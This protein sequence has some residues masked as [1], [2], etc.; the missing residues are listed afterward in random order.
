M[1]CQDCNGCNGS[2]GCCDDVCTNGNNYLWYISATDPTEVNYTSGPIAV[3]NRETVKFISSVPGAIR[4]EKGSVN[5]YIDFPLGLQGCQGDIGLQG[6]QGA[7]FQGLQGTQGDIGQQ[8]YQGAGFQGLQGTQGLQGNQGNIGLQGNQGAGFQGLQGYQGNTGLQGIQGTGFQGLQGNQGYQGYQGNQGVG[9][10]GNQGVQ[11]NQGTQGAQGDIGLQGNQGTGFQ[12]VQGTQGVQGAQGNI[13]LQG[14]QGAGFQG[15]QG[16]QGTQGTQGDIGLQGNQGVGFQG[17]QGTQGV[18]GAQGDIGLQGNQGAGFQGVQGTQGTQGAQGDIGLQGDIGS[19]GVQGTQGSIGVQGYQGAGLQGAQGIQGAQGFQGAVGLQGN[20]GTGFQGYQGN[21]GTGFQGV[22][23]NQG[24]QGSGASGPLLITRVVRP[25]STINPDT[26]V[27]LNT[28]NQAMPGYSILNIPVSNNIPS[29]IGVYNSVM[30]STGASPTPVF[31]LAENTAGQSFII[32]VTGTLPNNFASYGSPFIIQRRPLGGLLIPVGTNALAVVTGEPN[33]ASAD[34]YVRMYAVTGTSVTA[35]GPEYLVQTGASLVDCTRATTGILLGND[36]IIGIG[37]NSNLRFTPL[38]LNLGTT[39]PTILSTGTP[40]AIGIAYP[41][42]DPLA[43]SANTFVVAGLSAGVLSNQV[44]IAVQDNSSTITI[45]SILVTMSNGN[46]Y[47]S[48]Q[49]TLIPTGGSPPTV[50]FLTGT[51]PGTYGTFNANTTTLGITQ[52]SDQFLPGLDASYSPPTFGSSN[53]QF[54]QAMFT[55]NNSGTLTVYQNAGVLS[56]ISPYTFSATGTPTEISP[57]PYPSIATYALLN[58]AFLVSPS[59]SIVM[60]NSMSTISPTPQSQTTFIQTTF[61][62]NNVVLYIIPGIKGPYAIGISQ[63]SST[64]VG[65]GVLTIPIAVQGIATLV[66]T[67]LTPG[68]V[69]H[70]DYLGNLVDGY[71]NTA[72]VNFIAVATNQVVVI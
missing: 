23:G 16:N 41:Y 4:V 71:D 56:N 31:V 43:V 32:G 10:Q 47:A 42:S 1:S 68:H 59:I 9:I 62:G 61:S 13:G 63:N 67:T 44:I 33:G 24:L 14:N 38:T 50:N 49:P 58:T 69:Y 40:A 27:S 26:A 64:V 2:N 15:V 48:R 57:S 25:S 29:S 65:D 53:G 19:Q 45:G 17:V 36:L 52:L 20:Q 21:Q 11:G 5:V 35:E 34:Y 7:G 30:L 3:P 6:Y 51:G 39:P 37:G 8:G 12:G 72:P 22:Q 55:Q 46:N 66:A 54:A 28:S 18:Q 70:S 60:Q